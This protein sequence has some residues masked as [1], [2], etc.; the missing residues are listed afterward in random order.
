MNY[1]EKREIGK[2]MEKITGNGAKRGKC[3]W[4][5]NLS[6]FLLKKRTNYIGWIVLANKNTSFLNQRSLVLRWKPLVTGLPTPSLFRTPLLHAAACCCSGDFWIT[7]VIQVCAYV[8]RD[9]R[10]VC[11]MPSN[12]L[13]HKVSKRLLCRLCHFHVDAI[14][15]VCVC[16][17]LSNVWLHKCPS[18]YFAVCAIFVLMPYGVCVCVP[19]ASVPPFS[20]LPLWHPGQNWYVRWTDFYRMH[21]GQ[22]PGWWCGVIN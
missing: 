16:V 11:V 21:C 3:M 1:W 17:M 14:W 18:D 2:C 9:S 19:Y 6:H 7:C 22:V 13:L 5:H 4:G 20:A 10:H 15:C 8:I 12:V